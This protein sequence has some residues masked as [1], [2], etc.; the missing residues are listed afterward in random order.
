VGTEPFGG[1]ISNS[2]ATGSVTNNGV[3]KGTG[4][5]IGNLGTAVTLTNVYSTGKVTSTGLNVGGLVGVKSTFSTI[6]SSYYD[7]T[8]TGRTETTKGTP[9]TTAEL[10]QQATFTNWDFI[11]IW[12]IVEGSTY[13]T[14]R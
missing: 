9:K 13:P 4:G 12:K 6:A 5:F 7:K 11:T 2:Y 3:G 1:S 14:L 10:Y 8:T